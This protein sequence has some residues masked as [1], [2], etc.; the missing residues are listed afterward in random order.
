[1]LTDPLIRNAKPQAKPY[2][3]PREQGLYVIVNPNGAKLWRFAYQF[4]GEK[5][6]SF[7]AYPEVSLALARERR[8]D[9]RKLLA[10]GVDPSLH[11]RAE[12]AR[13][14]LEAENLFRVIAAEWLQMKA[15]SL[16]ARTHNKAKWMLD[17]ALPYIGD[18]PM[19]MI[20][21]MD[22]L[23]LLRAIEVTGRLETM[24][25][26]KARVSEVF[27][28]AIATGRAPSDPCRD[29]RGALKP[30]PPTQH[31]AALTEPAEVGRLA[32]A[33]HGYRGTLE[34]TA[35][36]KLSPLLF[37]RPGELRHAQWPEMDLDGKEPSWRYFVSKTKVHHIVPLCRQAVE[38][39]RELRPLT[40][41][42]KAFA[43]GTPQYVFPNSRTR[44]RPMSENAVN[45][46]LRG[47]G[48]SG[49]Q[50]TAHGF[51]AMARTLLA[52]LGWP[53]DAIER[54]L[55]HRPKGS[56]GDAYDRAQ[57]LAERRKMMQA[58]ADYLD[59]LKDEAVGGSLQRRQEA[60]ASRSAASQAA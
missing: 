7:G 34:V 28:Y 11:R 27:R 57:Y 3:L 13:K 1:M 41:H 38:V 4:D 12:A 10:A 9:A 18:M 16:S 42:G 30:K 59:Q 26:V 19:T 49:D 52:E 37:V 17:F 24:H 35:A 54:Q 21:P 25:R 39:L 8:E 36:L 46:A 44:H 55:A 60:W 50:M 58:W 45:A 33:I 15:G 29:L 32:H 23:G 53:P 22:V 14:S 43:P 2:K 47:L 5:L 56:L 6:L 40:D 31:L 20:Q 51:R 48:F